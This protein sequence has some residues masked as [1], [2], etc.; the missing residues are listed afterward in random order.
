MLSIFSV[1]CS[2]DIPSS[3]QRASTALTWIM[4]VI[5][6]VEAPS[7]QQLHGLGRKMRVISAQRQCVVMSWDNQG[8]RHHL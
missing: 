6:A 5:A 4:S 3:A 2:S 8:P 7:G 1:E